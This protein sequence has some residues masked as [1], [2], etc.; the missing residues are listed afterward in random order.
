MHYTVR[1]MLRQVVVASACLFLLARTYAQQTPATPPA[2]TQPSPKPPQPTGRITGTVFCADT[3][4]PARGAQ[5]RSLVGT[6]ITDAEGRYT[7]DHLKPGLQHIRAVLP[8]YITPDIPEAPTPDSNSSIPPS[9]LWVLVSPGETAVHN[10]TLER[11]AALSGRIYFADG[12]P[13][14]ATTVLVGRRSPVT[15]PTSPA[16]W[17]ILPNWM[18]QTT[19]IDDRGNYRISGLAPGTYRISAT[20]RL[21]GY[22]NGG[23]FN[24]VEA[25]SPDDDHDA[26]PNVTIYAGDTIHPTSART[27]TVRPGDEITGIDITIPL[28]ILRRV[29]GTVNGTDGL[30]INAGFITL[31]DSADDALRFRTDFHN[32][33][34]FLFAAIPPGTYK[35]SISHAFHGKPG[36]NANRFGEDEPDIPTNAYASFSTSILVKDSDLLDLHY[37]LTE[38]PMPPQKPDDS[39]DDPDPK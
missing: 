15:D 6:V 3:H 12:A 14:T 11:G 19:T 21:Q 9:D 39:N 27:F 24:L 5:V 38:I 18:T 4:K 33:G 31:I 37:D 20:P 7:I 32:D 26:F 22:G 8:G 17:T 30:S 2:T 1:K 16:M 36:S 25:P 28:A 35:L 34:S 29:H 23:N 13:A 10:I